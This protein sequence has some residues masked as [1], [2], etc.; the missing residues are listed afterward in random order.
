MASPTTHCLTV[1]LSW[2]DLT[3]VK[4]AMDFVPAL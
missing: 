2:P 1:L 4:L 3:V